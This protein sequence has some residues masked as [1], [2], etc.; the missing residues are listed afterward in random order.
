MN[1]APTVNDQADAKDSEFDS[2]QYHSRIVDSSDKIVTEALKLRYDVFHN[3]MSE[4]AENPLG[5]DHDP[6]D[7]VCK[8]IIIEDKFNNVVGTYRVQTGINAQEHLGYYS[9]NEFHM[10]P[11]EPIR[12]KLVEL[13][14]AC[15]HKDHRNGSILRKLWKSI[16]SFAL[17]N[18]AWYLIGCSSIHGTDH[19]EGAAHFREL[20]KSHLVEMRFR[21]LPLESGACRLETNLDKPSKKI[22]SLFAAYLA[23]G[24]KTCGPP[25]IDESF[26]TTDFLM[27]FDLKNAPD[28][29]KSKFFG[30]K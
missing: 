26:G 2:S 25:F 20:R 19:N 22:P 8:H 29:V 7:R 3:E 30:M 17:E 12:S 28:R 18:D 23:V 1:E 6:F 13:G 5:L 27:F 21:T 16:A 10:D 15:V 11:F 24:A 14:R 9:A 4:G